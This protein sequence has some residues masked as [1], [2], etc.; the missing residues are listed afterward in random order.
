MKLSELR[1]ILELSQLSHPGNDILERVLDK[2]NRGY[3]YAIVGSKRNAAIIR[4]LLS[5]DE[6]VVVGDLAGLI[7]EPDQ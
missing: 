3:N 6:C 5:D 1:A 2:S 7:W 4:D